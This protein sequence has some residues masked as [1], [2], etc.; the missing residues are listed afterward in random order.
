MIEA[1]QSLRNENLDKA[2]KSITEDRNNKQKSF[3]RPYWLDYKITRYMPVTLLF[4]N[5]FGGPAVT[6]KIEDTVS[7]MTI[8]SRSKTE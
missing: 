6:L 7:S 4:I 5:V 8:R 3:T 2:E 1:Q